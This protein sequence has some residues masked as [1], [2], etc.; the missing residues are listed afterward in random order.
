[1][2]FYRKLISKINVANAIQKVVAFNIT[3][4]I[5][6][7]EDKIG[8]DRLTRKLILFYAYR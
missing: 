7:H 4:F 8:F 5:D 6:G 2:F 1:M 3:N